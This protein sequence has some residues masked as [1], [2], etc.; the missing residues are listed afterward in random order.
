MENNNLTDKELGR[1][2]RAFARVR[3]AHHIGIKIEKVERGT[4]TVYFEDTEPLKQNAGVVHGG[5]IASLID[6]ATAFAIIPFL[7]EGQ[8]A[9]TI[10][11]TIHFLRPITKGKATATAKVIRAGKKIITAS[12]E[13]FDE[14]ER[15]TATALTTYMRQTV[16][17][18]Q[19][20]SAV[21]NNRQPAIGN[22]QSS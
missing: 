13:V 20:Q 12:A 17:G 22:R 4:A 19:E 10:D 11:L 15:L 16:S 18:R 14:S 9:T 5:A 8:S 6:T 1:I 7:E 3:Y 21:K 2:R